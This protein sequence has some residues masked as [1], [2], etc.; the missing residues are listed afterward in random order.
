[1]PGRDDAP[2]APRRTTGRATEGA[3]RQARP[4]R[5]RHDQSAQDAL[6]PEQLTWIR[7]HHERPDGEGYP[8]GLAHDAIG[9]G[10]RL[11]ALA[12]AYDIMTT[13]GTYQPRRTAAEALVEC[14]RLAGHQFDT[15]MVEALHTLVTTQTPDDRPLGPSTPPP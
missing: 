15:R 4:F 1:M 7:G 14:D 11:I 2:D 6:T 13:V 12:D 10:A 5:C 3:R 9:D 8:D